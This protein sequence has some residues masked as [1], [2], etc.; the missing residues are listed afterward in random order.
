[1]VDQRYNWIQNTISTTDIK[2]EPFDSNYSLLSPPVTPSLSS[3]SASTLG[4]RSSTSSSAGTT[5]LQPY[6]SLNCGTS[7]VE[8]S[9]IM[10]TN[11][12]YGAWSSTRGNVRS[13]PP[14][15]R[16]TSDGNGHGAYAGHD[17]ANA[18]FITSISSS[19]M[20]PTSSGSSSLTGA[21][22]DSS[23]SRHSRPSP[24]VNSMYTGHPEQNMTWNTPQSL[25]IAMQNSAYPGVAG[26][27]MP[28]QGLTAPDMGLYPTTSRNH[29]PESL[30][31]STPPYPVGMYDDS[32]LR[33]QMIMPQRA[34]SSLGYPMASPGPFISH[35]LSPSP[36]ET[37]D[38]EVRRLRRRIEEL[39]LECSRTRAALDAMRS[40]GLSSAG[41][42]TPPV[43]A[44]FQTS[45]K[46]RT[47]VRKRMFCSLNRAGNALCAWH[48][49]RRERRAHPPR[50]APDGY[51]NCG[52]TVEAALFEESLS[53]HGVGSYHPGESVRMD[54]ALRNPLLKL[55]EQ[56]YGYK[57]G[58]FERDPSTGDWVQGESPLDW[59]R[60]AQSGSNSRRRPDNDRH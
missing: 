46:A 50:L 60:R 57:D 23:I 21:M 12:G 8:E 2:E 30:S 27:N 52:C 37:S 44:S 18:S 16:R 33:G 34:N 13:H 48:D 49:S 11:S 59:D 42:P 38:N 15:E 4:C 54:P 28:Y 26:S 14:A 56:R 1:M 36:S 17:Y 10:S 51:L 55:L 53:R 31:P 40:S 39:E 45:W 22:G 6:N 5:R 7:R 24:L 32:C 29:S 19:D 43:S 20:R 41:L 3:S 9:G 35:D 25:N 47:E 58:D